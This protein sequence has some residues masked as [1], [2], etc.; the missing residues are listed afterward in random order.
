[1]VL[2]LGGREM[3]SL[4]SLVTQGDRGVSYVL[5]VIYYVYLH[6]N[7]T[8]WT[9]VGVL[10]WGAFVGAILWVHGQWHDC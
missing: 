2:W 10:M 1:M 9:F 5:M 7:L 6:V 3:I 8:S 4:V